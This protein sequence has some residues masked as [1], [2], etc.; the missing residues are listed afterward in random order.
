MRERQR[1]GQR[2]QPRAAASGKFSPPKITFR[3]HTSSC[4]KIRAIG[5]SSI[6]LHR[7][8]PQPVSE[9]LLEL[10]HN[11]NCEAE[12]MPSLELH[13][14]FD[15]IAIARLGGRYWPPLPLSEVA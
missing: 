13:C 8:G 15:A 10:A 12:L 2:R 14:E 4:T 3:P 6:T 7:L 5:T 9:R 1:P 11:R